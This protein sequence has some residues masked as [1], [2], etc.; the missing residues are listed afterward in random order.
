[1]SGVVR[2]FGPPPTFF[3]VFCDKFH[4]KFHLTSLLKSNF[5]GGIHSSRR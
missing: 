2:P 1:M 3:D 4:D 5:E